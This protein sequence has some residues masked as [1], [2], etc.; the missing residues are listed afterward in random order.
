M[1][2]HYADFNFEIESANNKLHWLKLTPQEAVPCFIHL[3][4]W[5]TW[6]EMSDE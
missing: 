5:A 6:P 3:T 1:F 4:F 2:N